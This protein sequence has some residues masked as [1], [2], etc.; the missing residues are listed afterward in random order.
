VV[1][2]Y[3]IKKIF[4]KYSKYYILH[5]ER[6]KEVIMKVTKIIIISIVLFS[7]LSSCQY[8]P[9][10]N[11]A[12]QVSTNTIQATETSHLTKWEYKFYAYQAFNNPEEDI[13]KALNDLGNEGWELVSITSG[14]LAYIFV[15]KRPIY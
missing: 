14:G 2:A 10:T 15:F 3:Q 5:I 9:T 11:A 12:Q 7:L 6:K 1:V 8:L 4:I 13:T